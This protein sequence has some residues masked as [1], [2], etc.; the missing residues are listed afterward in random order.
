MKGENIEERGEA[1]REVVYVHGCYHIP[2]SSPSKYKMFPRIV[3]TSPA[4]KGFDSFS[5]CTLLKNSAL[6]IE[7]FDDHFVDG[8]VKLTTSRFF[9]RIWW[10]SKRFC[11]KYM[12]VQQ[13]QISELR[14]ALRG[15]QSKPQCELLKN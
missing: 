2:S 10:I 14:L 4:N 11:E 5:N 13:R 12:T 15:L 6:V 8:F 3:T 1:R 7:F 9:P